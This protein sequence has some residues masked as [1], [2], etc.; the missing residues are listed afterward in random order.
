[1]GVLHGLGGTTSSALAG[2]ARP[3]WRTARPALFR[4]TFSEPREHG[5]GEAAALEDPRGVSSGIA[6]A[7]IGWRASS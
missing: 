5:N 7:G 3:R 2:Q 4:S 1:V 6:I